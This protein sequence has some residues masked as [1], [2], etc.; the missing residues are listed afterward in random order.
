MTDILA[1]L[2]AVQRWVYDSI[3]VYL[4]DFSATA[5]WRAL[6]TVLPLGIVFGAVHALTPGHGKT[7]L[8]SYLVGSRTHVLKSLGVAAVLSATHVLSAVL[9]ALVGAP[10]LSRT[11]TGAGRSD[12]IEML[13]RGLIALIGVWLLIRAV[14]RR[15]HVHGEGVLVGFV[16]GLVPCP[17]TLFAMLL[18]ISRGVPEAGLTFAAAMLIGISLTLGTVAVVTTLARDGV[19]R[20]VERYGTSMDR[21][22]RA[23]DAVAGLLLVFL[24]LGAVLR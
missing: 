7:V 8:A 2:V 17:L 5:D 15:P 16:A 12:S 20:I 19:T 1:Y 10:I 23:L 9:I 14:R 3:S 6:L 11:L 24:G 13:S 18:S 22:T 4:N 21:I